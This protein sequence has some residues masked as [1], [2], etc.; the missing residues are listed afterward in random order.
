MG[1]GTI[2]QGSNYKKNKKENELVDTL[3][4]TMLN[5]KMCLDEISKGISHK[6]IILEKE[7]I[8]PLNMF[9]QHYTSDNKDMLKQANDLWDHLHMSRT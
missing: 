2:N 6:N 7:L 1:G 3:S 5:V 9:H 8:E 4:T